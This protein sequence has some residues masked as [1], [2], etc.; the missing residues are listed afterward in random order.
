MLTAPGYANRPANLSSRSFDLPNKPN[1]RF[2]SK[3]QQ[4]QKRQQIELPNESV[5]L[6]ESAGDKQSHHP[7]SRIQTLP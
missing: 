3:L 2:Q 5:G 4:I 6:P 7:F 1:S